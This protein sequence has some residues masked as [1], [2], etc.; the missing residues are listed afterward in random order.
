M[1][2]DSPIFLE[3][4]LHWLCRLRHLSGSGLL[5]GRDLWRSASPTPL[6]KAGSARVASWGHWPIG[7]CTSPRMK[8]PVFSYLQSIFFF[9]VYRM[10]LVFNLLQLLSISEHCFSTVPVKGKDFPGYYSEIVSL[11]DFF[12]CL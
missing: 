5:C 6:L 1:C 9:N 10:F 12:F 7:L 3:A 4:D 8:T 11:F 2:T